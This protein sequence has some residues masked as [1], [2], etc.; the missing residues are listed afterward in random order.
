MSWQHACE[1]MLKCTF[2]GTF[3]AY[4]YIEYVYMGY[5]SPNKDMTCYFI[6]SHT[7]S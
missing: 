7:S 4:L 5:I 2:V 6:S 3:L 1:T